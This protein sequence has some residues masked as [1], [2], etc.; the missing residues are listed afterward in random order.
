MQ[1][2]KRMS[3]EVKRAL[4]ASQASIEGALATIPTPAQ[5]MKFLDSLADVVH[6]EMI[7]AGVEFELQKPDA[8]S[9]EKS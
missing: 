3:A 7:R 9:G 5:R 6:A 2:P 4:L 1:L 8:E